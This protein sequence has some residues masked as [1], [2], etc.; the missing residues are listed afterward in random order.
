VNPFS[1]INTVRQAY[2]SYVRSYQTFKDKHIEDWVN[3]NISEGGLLWKSPYI[4]LLRRFKPGE[5]F[6]SERMA[7]ILHKD[8]KKV[9]TIEAGNRNAHPILPH[10]HQTD[11]IINLIERNKN[12]VIATGTGSGKS[13]CFGIP[14]VSRCLEMKEKGIKGIKAL[15]IYPMNALANSQYEDFALRLKDSG[16]TI[17]LYTGDTKNSRDVALRDFEELIGRKEPYNSELISRDEIRDK[18]PDILMTNYQ[19]LELLLTRFEDRELFPEK[20]GGVLQFLILDEVHTYTG[21]RGADVA[22]LIR[23]LKQHTKTIGKIRCIATSATVQSGDEEEAKA[24]IAD[25]ASRLLG[26][27][28]DKDS[29]IGED[30][31]EIKKFD[32]NELFP[33]P[34]NA[35]VPGDLIQN[36]DGSLESI[37]KLSEALLGR[38]LDD[39]ERNV[40][41]LSTLFMKNK[42]MYFIEDNLSKKPMQIEEI[43][44][45]FLQKENMSMD[46]DKAYRLVY[47]SL[48]LGMFLLEKHG[49]NE[50]KRFVPK[51]H[52]FVTQGR[53]LLGCITNGEI[54]FNKSGDTVCPECMKNGL[55]NMQMFPLFFCRACGQMFYGISYDTY[56]GCVIPRER[57]DGDWKGSA[58]YLVK[59]HVDI[60]QIE[61]PVNWLKA[62]GELKN[63]KKMHMPL[64][65]YYDYKNA[66]LYDFE[67]NKDCIPVTLINFP[68]M[69]CPSCSTYYDYRSK[70]FSKLF[71]FSTAGRSTSTDIIISEIINNLPEKERKLISFSDNRQDTALQAGHI[72]NLYHRVLFRQVL[73]NT[74]IEKG[75]IDGEY[76][77]DGFPKDLPLNSVGREVFET[78]YK[79]DIMPNYSRN[80]G[81][82]FGR[83]ANTDE[84]KYKRYLTF[85]L[86]QDLKSSR[87]KNQ[88][89]LLDVGLLKINYDGLEQLVYDE[90][91]LRMKTELLCEYEPQLRYDYMLGILDEMV[92]FGALNHDDIIRYYEFKQE[93]IDQIN[94][95]AKFNLGDWEG[96]PAGYTE[97]RN[98]S[99]V[100]SKKLY[101]QR[102]FINWTRKALEIEDKTEAEKML[103]ETINLL[104]SQEVGLL[105]KENP[106]RY[107]RDIVMLNADKI[108]LQVKKSPVSRACPK[109]GKVF[110]FKILSECT[111]ATCGSLEDIGYS[112]NYF[113]IK[114]SEKLTNKVRLLAAEHSGQISGD[115]RKML[116]HKFRDLKELNVLMCTPTM[117]L[118]I[119]IGSLS[120]IYMRNVPPN[121]SNYAQRAGR[122]GRKSQPA[123]IVTFCGTG[124]SRGPHDQYFYR[125][126]E[127]I[128]SGKISVP[129]FMLDNKSLM[130]THIHSLILEITDFRLPSKPKE[131]MDVQDYMNMPLISSLRDQIVE[132][133]SKP[134][135]IPFIMSC[136]KQAFSAEMNLF[137]WFNEEFINNVIKN[138]ESEF[139]AAFDRFRDEY[140][141]LNLEMEEIN[142]KLQFEGADRDLHYRQGV[143]SKKLESMREGAGDFYTYRYLG[144]E[145]F[146]PNYAFPRS[147][148]NLSFY[149]IEDD[150]TRG[151]T[152][153]LNEF[154]PG[155]SVYYKGYR[156]SVTYA[157]PKT[158]GG[159]PDFKKALVCPNCSEIYLYEYG[160][161]EDMTVCINCGYSLEGIRPSE[162]ALELPDMIG[163]RK[164]NITSDE[165]ERIRLGYEIQQHY[166]KGRSVNTYIVTDGDGNKIFEMT[167]EHNGQIV[168]VNRGPRTKTEEGD[169]SG[170]GFVL[171]TK[172]NKW[173]LSDES[174]M[175]HTNPEEREYCIKKAEKDDI[176][177]LIELFT[178]SNN[179]VLALKY[180]EETRE[181][182]ESFYKTLLYALVQGV[183]VT[184]NVD[185]SEIGAFLLKDYRNS[186]EF[187]IV[188]YELA[189]G[190]EGI[191]QSMTEPRQLRLVA[192]KALEI[193]HYGD[194]DGCEK[195]CYECLCNY[196]N[197]HDYLKLDRKL[198]IPLLEKMRS[199]SILGCDMVEKY[200]ELYKKC[201][202]GLEKK[203]LELI[204]EKG[205]KLPDEAQKTIYID[206]VPIAEAD[207]YYEPKTVV[208]IDGEFVHGQEHISIADEDKRRKLKA[209][210]YR[211]IVINE[212]AFDDDIRRL[213][214]IIG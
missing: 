105:K 100:R 193:L 207:F 68:F 58:G 121:P 69:I 142:R 178:T 74:L 152:I 149:D 180:V 3:K 212:T 176:I 43:A 38:K 97:E 200:D 116:E 203:F 67:A 111:S 148:T 16:L 76:G 91:Y 54:H 92:R 101:S 192:D 85:M 182:S 158:S 31:V 27:D 167:Y 156:Y 134:L 66:I 34:E 189:P 214:N 86:I 133:I 165:E 174:I 44:E 93:V 127:K 114:Y 88:Q 194:E 183:Q 205:C 177:T 71:N 108:R 210:G 188:I 187:I 146:L 129:R 211:I 26:E 110:N 131:I 102:S 128:I 161:R 199:I 42:L 209:K 80:I 12:T 29:V 160:D 79:Y 117:E 123:I 186:N 170:K 95:E 139:D 166:K 22:C 154:A 45:L 87:I 144:A 115:D 33:L 140:R 7:A 37:I 64:H 41:Q 185:E 96:M 119:D 78:Y 28:F 18:K 172:C 19:M 118:G 89:N 98:V 4:S 197:Q 208:F 106:N 32:E 195:A 135:N 8:T 145:G 190:G 132:K 124:S 61:F 81:S 49:D 126:T 51:V 137:E 99:Y 63:D 136:V 13:F 36:F 52:N 202:S 30:Y 24:I 35:D 21:K 141:N 46:Y 153:A 171:C 17:A 6:D 77:E 168:T 23:R 179:D 196:Y 94:E 206:D 11:A 59:E 164:G 104:L 62:N 72:N 155:N 143:I 84:E 107:A 184:F 83:V 150:I 113:F 10:K 5:P 103:K 151:K 55:E 191:V 112:N 201:E 204:K 65:K 173:L 163:R 147:N 57:D 82:K 9:F 109:C 48:L 1:V 120:A 181:T 60:N 50:T 70:E 90:E 125:F 20:D 157:K 138:F 159:V 75:Y 130:R 213:L 122:A 56:S 169:Y 73:Y 53:S 15:I 175:N 14:V 25:F 198:V 40:E 39:G 162:H 2:I 47:G